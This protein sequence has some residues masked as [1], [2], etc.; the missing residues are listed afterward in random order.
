MIRSGT[1]NMILEKEREGK[2]A[3]A[4]GKELGVAENTAKKYINQ[5]AAE[6]GL[7]GPTTGSKLDEFKTAINLM[8]SQGVH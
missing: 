2:R 3:Y 8:L 4:I 7:K 5:P 1:I 6:H